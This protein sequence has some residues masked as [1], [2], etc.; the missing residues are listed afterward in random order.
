MGFAIF[1]HFRVN[2]CN[3]GDTVSIKIKNGLIV[4]Q[5]DDHYEQILT[6]EIIC[7]MDEGYLVHIPQDLYLQN[8]FFITKENHQEYKIPI[9]FLDAQ[10]HYISGNHIYEVRSRL[11]GAKCARCDEWVNMAGET[12]WG[13]PF[14]CF[15]CRTYKWRARGKI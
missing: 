11:D 5:Y 2:E 12:V 14:V 15:L 6:V 3:P 8:S 9:Q 13:E 10:A 4:N 7:L 1:W